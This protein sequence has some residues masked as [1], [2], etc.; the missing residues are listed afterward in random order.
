MAGRRSLLTT[1]EAVVADIEPGATLGFA[2]L[3]TASHSMPIVRELIRRGIGDLHVVG[4]ASGLEVDMLIAAGLVRRVSAATV[5]GDTLEMI[6]P[7]FRREA[8]AGR[9]EVWECDEGMVYAALQAAAQRLDFAPLPVGLGG[10]YADLNEGMEVIASPFTGRPVLAIKAIPLD[11]CFI[12]AAASDPFGNVQFVG[13][14]FGARA[15]ARAAE[16]IVC[17]VEQVIDNT[18]VRANPAATALAGV[19]D[20][21]HAPFGAHPFAS[22]GFY[23]YDEPLLREYLDAAKHWLRSDERGPLD[24][25]FEQ[26]ILVPDSHWAYLDMVGSQRLYALGETLSDLP[27]GDS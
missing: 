11:F 12:H 3:L 20:V 15:F 9:I 2:G 4:T 24:A 13:G 1:A 8:Q 14:G 5:S 23:I 16:R 18:A 22:P 17:T 7:A 6:G 26:W 10:S 19:H 25:F 21:I 27:A